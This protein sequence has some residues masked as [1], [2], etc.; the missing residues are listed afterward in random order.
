M[1]SEGPPF[2]EVFVSR[3]VSGSEK[4]AKMSQK[5]VQKEV[6]NGSVFGPEKWSVFSTPS[7]CERL[8]KTYQNIGIDILTQ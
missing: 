5:G 8:P 6:Q 7:D 3:T 2:S 1:S 4:D